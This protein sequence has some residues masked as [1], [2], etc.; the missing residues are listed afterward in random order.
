M[1]FVKNPVLLK[2]LVS[3]LLGIQ[4]ES[5]NEF[6][7]TN[8]EMPPEYYGDKFCRLDINMTVDRQQL[9]LEIQVEDEGDFPARTLYHWAREY[10]TALPAGGKYFDLPR[11]IVISIVAFKLFSCVE[12]H[13]EFHALEVTRHIPL[14]DKFC[15]M[16]FELPKIPKMINKDDELLLWL[17]LFK[18]E[19]EEELAAIKALEVPVME[20]AIEAYRSITAS[21]EFREMERLRAKA[22]HDEAQALWN[23]EQQTNKKWQSIVAEKDA[24]LADK[25]ELIA[26]LLKQ[27]K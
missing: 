6:M 7:I 3:K 25:D 15:L 22:R 19:T 1:L 24:A 16:Y 18:A 13:S 17:L 8:P 11:T 9:N 26:K 21:P 12:Y 4:P 23:R 2:R 14:T 10:S 20:Q 27:V 5:I